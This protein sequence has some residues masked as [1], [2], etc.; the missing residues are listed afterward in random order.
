MFL[1]AYNMRYVHLRVVCDE[2]EMQQRVQDS[3]RECEILQFGGVKGYISADEVVESYHSSGVPKSNDA[4]HL[5]RFFF[6]FFHGNISLVCID[7]L[8]QIFLIYKSALGLS[9][10]LFPLKAEPLQRFNYVLFVCRV[11]PFLVGIFTAKDYLAAT[12][13]REQ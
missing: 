5:S 10:K 9:V 7:K 3:A 4:C 6:A 2:C 1:A 11:A 12:S 13:A 8:F